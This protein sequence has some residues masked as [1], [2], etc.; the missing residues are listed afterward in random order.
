MTASGM[1]PNVLSGHSV[2]REDDQKMT[3]LRTNQKAALPV[4]LP[5]AGNA[6]T[7]QMFIDKSALEAVI[8]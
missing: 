6:Q 8:T 4:V 5:Y 7:E 3:R 1:L 2:K